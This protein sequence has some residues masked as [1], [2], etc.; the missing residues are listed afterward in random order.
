MAGQTRCYVVGLT[1]RSAC[2]DLRVGATPAGEYNWPW[3]GV[4][5]PLGRGAEEGISWSFFDSETIYQKQRELGVRR[6][7]S[8]KIQ[9]VEIKVV[10]KKALLRESGVPKNEGMS[11]DVYEN[12]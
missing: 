12:K 8:E 10:L 2:A 9:V 1:F 5:P 4:H 3:G 6:G 7:F 11:V